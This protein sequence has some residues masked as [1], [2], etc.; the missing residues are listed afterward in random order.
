M[1]DT[2]IAK[3]K[4]N[5]CFKQ[6]SSEAKCFFEN[7]KEDLL[8]RNNDLKFDSI[9]VNA[10]DNLETLFSK[11]S[12]WIFT[13]NVN[14]SPFTVKELNKGMLGFIFEGLKSEK[15]EFSKIAFEEF[16]KKIGK[17]LEHS[18]DISDKL[19]KTA[20]EEMCKIHSNKYKTLNVNVF[21]DFF[22]ND[23]KDIFVP[24]LFFITEMERL[25]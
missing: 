16:S 21:L 2:T 22:H 3:K 18:S 1:I 4:S 24:T 17:S 12:S 7:M 20:E 6:I 11:K 14:W 8:Y 23:E 9:E 10:S 13:C 15:S 25:R 5:C 19:T